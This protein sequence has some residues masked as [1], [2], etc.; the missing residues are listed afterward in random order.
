M[1]QKSLPQTGSL[2]DPILVRQL[3]ALAGDEILYRLVKVASHA[4]GADQAKAM[5]DAL[6]RHLA[7]ALMGENPQFTPA[8]K[9]SG[10]PC[11]KSLA[12]CAGSFYEK[13]KAEEKNPDEGNPRV[14]MVLA[15]TAFE[16]NL[17]AAIE[18]EFQKSDVSE[19]S[20]RAA[21]S[22]VVDRYALAAMKPQVS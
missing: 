5:D 16:R 6:A 4:F 18:A 11:A 12:H 8:A 10:E 2:A 20:V 1:T 22:S 3:F 19:A 13:V 15:V 7:R 14:V 17:Y 9:W 21:V